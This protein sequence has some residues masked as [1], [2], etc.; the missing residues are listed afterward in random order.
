M[1]KFRHHSAFPKA[2]QVQGFRFPHVCFNCRKSFKFPVQFSARLCPECRAPM[3][4]LS[5]KFSA[6]KSSDR[7]QWEKVRYLVES[8]FLFYSASEMVGPSASKR[9]S[10]PRTLQEAKLFVERFK[11]QLSPGPRDAWPFNREDAARQ[12]GQRLSSQRI[13]RT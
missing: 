5:R 11:S 13:G 6:P 9:V 7:Q 1:S 8:G 12:A 2:K 10:Y 3:I 4:R